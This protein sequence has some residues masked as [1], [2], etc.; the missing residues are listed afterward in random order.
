M[1]IFNIER[2]L[3]ATVVVELFGVLYK[4]CE[5]DSPFGACESVWSKNT[6]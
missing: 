2:L 4:M 5:T 1:S 6:Y 3:L